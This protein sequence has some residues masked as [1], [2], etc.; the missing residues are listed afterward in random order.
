MSKFFSKF[1]KVCKRP[2]TRLYLP[3]NPPS[4]KSPNAD[5]TKV[6]KESHTN[7]PFNM[8]YSAIAA[9]LDALKDP[10]AI[11]DRKMLVSHPP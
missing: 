2:P 9:T 10:N 5:S 7:L 4:W 11:D 6:I 8:E 1:Q 3:V